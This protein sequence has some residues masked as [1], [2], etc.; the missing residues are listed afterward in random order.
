MGVPL[1]RELR[2]AE[3]AIARALEYQ[4]SLPT[5]YIGKPYEQ[6]DLNAV[7]D[8]RQALEELL[9][10][11]SRKEHILATTDIDWSLQHPLACRPDM[12][13]CPVHKAMM[14][15]ADPPVPSGR[16]IVRLAGGELLYEREASS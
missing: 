16:W 14:A 11:V 7:V 8:I 1:M 13:A 15:V 4:R 9:G 3:A 2:Q 10:L 12:L 6:A 5:R